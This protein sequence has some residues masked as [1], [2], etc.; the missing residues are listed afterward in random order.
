MHPIFS[1]QHQGLTV[2]GFSRCSGAD[3]LS[4]AELKL[5]FDLGAQP[6]SF[7][8]TQRGLSRMGTWIISRHYPCMWRDDA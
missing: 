3:L 4:T 1:L 7:M 8:G 6:W 5:G 2:E